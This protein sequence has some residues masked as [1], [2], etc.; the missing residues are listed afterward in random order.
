M[1]KP[2]DNANVL[3]LLQQIWSGVMK[4]LRIC[5]TCSKTE[6]DSGLPLYSQ[7]YKRKPWGKLDIKYVWERVVLSKIEAQDLNIFMEDFHSYSEHVR[8][9]HD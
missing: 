5:T 6:M 2:T 4:E 3:D 1:N 8:R 9:N 7:K